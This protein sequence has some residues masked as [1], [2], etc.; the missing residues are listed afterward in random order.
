MVDA[1]RVDRVFHGREGILTNP[2]WR[3]G[4]PSRCSA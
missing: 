4:S 3:L 1:C 2:D